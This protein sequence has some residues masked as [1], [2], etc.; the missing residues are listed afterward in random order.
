MEEDVHGVVP[1]QREEFARSR[2]INRKLF[3]W[4]RSMIEVNRLVDFKCNLSLVIKTL[5]KKK[6]LSLIF[7]LF[8]ENMR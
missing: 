6:V 5:K 1:N 8:V 4:R 3:I 7:F 2:G